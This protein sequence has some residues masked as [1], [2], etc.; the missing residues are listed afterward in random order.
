MAS[1]AVDA[2]LERAWEIARRLPEF[3]KYEL[4]DFIEFLSDRDEED[5]VWHPDEEEMAELR[6]FFAGEAE[7]GVPWEQVKQE[8]RE[9]RD[10]VQD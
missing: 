9:S 1:N 2:H 7:V 10:R 5:A 3:R 6:A 4:I 8:M